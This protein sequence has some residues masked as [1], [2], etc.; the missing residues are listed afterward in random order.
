MCVPIYTMFN[1]LTIP[2][3]YYNKHVI[4]PSKIIIHVKPMFYQLYVLL[5]TVGSF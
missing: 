3:I 4:I 5:H 2:Y 1:I